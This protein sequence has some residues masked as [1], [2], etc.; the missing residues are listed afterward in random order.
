[1]K[2]RI[3]LNLN[4]IDKTYQVSRAL[5]SEARL[6]ILKILLEKSCNLSE[7]SEKLDLPLST[8]ANHIHILEEA[9]LISCTEQPGARGS[10][11]ICG[12]IFQGI[13][14]DSQVYYRPQDVTQYI[15]PMSIGN[16]FD[17]DITS[18]S[19]ICSETGYIGIEDDTSAFYD[20]QRNQAQILWFQ[21][22]SIEY[23]FPMK[24]YQNQEITSLN[25]SLELCS[26]APGYNN[27]WPSDIEVYLDNKYCGTIHSEGDFG[28]SRGM[29]NPEWWSNGRTQHGILHNVSIDSNKAYINSSP[30]E[31]LSLEDLDLSK[32][33]LS[34]KLVVRGDRKNS[35]GDKKTAGGINLFGE[36]FGNHPQALK[37]EISTKRVEGSV[38]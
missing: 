12:V 18:P 34:F 1:M 4:N 38:V 31:N 29:L 28:G 35:S 6:K 36:K 3:Y 37:L 7:L 15:V 25:I 26:E 21:S 24:Q 30:A 10:Q 14:V 9:E 32:D 8:I 2:K 33:Y 27:N 17:C 11:K 20:N 13:Y 5:A 16:Y 19:G 22:G 23:R